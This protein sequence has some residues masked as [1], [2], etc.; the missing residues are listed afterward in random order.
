MS[1]TVKAAS[2]PRRSVSA[3][4]CVILLDEV[5]KAHPDVL[6]MFYQ[7]FDRGLMRD[8]EGREIDFKNTVIIMTSNLGADE[9]LDLFSAAESAEEAE[10]K[11]PDYVTMYNTVMPALQQHF[12]AAP[13]GAYPGSSN[14]PLTTGQPANDYHEASRSGRR[15]ASM[16]PTPSR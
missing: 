13:A 1:V 9:L 12:P 10:E 6:N 3:P 5:E 4:Y 8:G 14:G 16:R 15:G 7:V 11:I 2:S